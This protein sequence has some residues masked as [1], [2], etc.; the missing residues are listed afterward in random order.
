MVKN[1]WLLLGLFIIGTIFLAAPGA[2]PNQVNLGYQVGLTIVTSAV[3]LF[4]ERLLSGKP[5]HELMDEISKLH[6]S[7][8]KLNEGRD[9]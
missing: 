4:F 6:A 9:S 7:T 5:D 8:D 3:F 1:V 2:D